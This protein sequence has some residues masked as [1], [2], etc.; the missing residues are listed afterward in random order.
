MAAL[1]LRRMGQISPKA[2]AARTGPAPIANHS[3]KRQGRRSIGGGRKALRDIL[4]L[5][6]IGAARP[7][8]GF[9]AV[10]D[11][12]TTAGK[13]CRKAIIAV[14]RKRITTLN[15]MIRDGSDYIPGPG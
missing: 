7:D 13:A 5:A 14:A 15:A 11:R 2:S 6:A 3:G 9:R 1:L 4:H 12:R 8:P 10:K